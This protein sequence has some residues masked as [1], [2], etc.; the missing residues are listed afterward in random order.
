MRIL[1]VVAAVA[2]VATT[3]LAQIPVSPPA[4]ITTSGDSLPAFERPNG[5]LMRTGA[6]TYA[7][8][9]VKSSREVA[10][11]GTR[12]VTVSESALGGNPGW[13]IA[14]SRN[15][16]AVTTTDSVFLARTDFAPLRWTATIGH[17]QFAASFSRDSMFGVSDTYQGRS[18]F[19]AALP[20]N[21]L[22]SSGMVERVVEMLPLRDGYRTGATLVLV[23]GATPQLVPA[24]IVVER[25]ERISLGDRTLDV[26]R[27]AVRAGAIEERLWVSRDG[28][29]VVRTEQA[30]AGGQLSQRLLP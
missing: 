3:S 27:V 16:T 22:L 23:A 20:A 4:Q 15:G 13:L 28:A 25:Q 12:T 1:V 29:R 19:A 21:A 30:L 24:E 10:P 11:M 9:L 2:A 18:S 8:S 26:W 5:A 6:L 17:A 14:E 7:V